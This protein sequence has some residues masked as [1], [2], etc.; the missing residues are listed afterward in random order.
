MQPEP[1]WRHFY[2]ITQVPRPSKKEEQILKYL[3]DL[4]G[5]MN[6]E[7]TE[8][9]AGNMVV[10]K[11]ASPGYENAPTVLIQGHVDMVCEKNKGTEHDFEK[12]PIKLIRD[13]DW[14]TADGTTLGADN[15]IGVAAG[16]A[17]LEAKDLTHGPMEFLFTVDEETGMTGAKE[18][19][20]GFLNSDIMLNLDS[21]EDGTLYVGCAGGM[22]TAGIMHMRREDAPAGF[23][24]LEI[25]VGGLKGGHSGLDIHTGRGNAIKMLARTLQIVKNGHGARLNSFIGGSKRNAIPREAEAVVYVPEADVND[26]I[27]HMAKVT[28][29]LLNEISTVEPDLKVTAKEVDADGK[30]LDDAQFSALIN[31]LYACPHGVIKMSADIPG[32]VETSTNLATVT[33]DDGKII[34]GTSQRS[35]VE[36][37]KQDCTNMVKAVFELAGLKVESGDGYPGWKPNMQ[38]KA[39]KAT[40]DA[41][42]ELF[43]DEPEVTAIH[44]GLECGLINEVFPNLDIIS[45][46]PTIEGAHSPDERLNIPATEKFWTLLTKVLENL[47]KAK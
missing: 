1:V 14:I 19:K 39:L 15:G 45:F 6:I 18:L 4:L 21:E 40:K 17:V 41:Y 8:D 47:A 26:I 30:V 3:K 38:S 43:G 31:A 35:S 9:S 32:L 5:D 24:A 2:G 37:E 10:K 36:S 44:A 28:E 11:A 46:G 27:A 23:K 33:M 7:Y 16:L 29:M 22:D 34:V 13:G 25:N 20:P 12:D 42:K